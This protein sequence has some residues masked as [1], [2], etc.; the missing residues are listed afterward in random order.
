MVTAVK[1]K[2]GGAIS[3]APLGTTLPTAADGTLNEAFKNF[4][5]VSENGVTRS[6]DL[7]TETV[8]A[9][10]GD[11]VMVLDNGRTETFQF[12]LLEATSVDAMKLVNGDGN[13]TG[14]DLASGISV[15]SNNAELVGH[16]FV[17]DMIEHQNTLHRIVIP[18]G[19]VTDIGDITYVD[20]EALQSSVTITAVA[21]SSGNTA[22][23]YL[24]TAAV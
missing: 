13:V 20:N 4:G 7:S 17:I 1:P 15:T 2:V 21:D 3:I 5:Y 19:V 18:N 24:K 10:G 16:A 23:E 8:K 9:W 14:G 22:Y 12:S 6:F 11:V